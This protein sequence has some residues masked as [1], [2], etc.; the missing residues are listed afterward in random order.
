MDRH[1]RH[2]LE[3]TRGGRHEI[4][5]TEFWDRPVSYLYGLKVNG[6]NFMVL[7]VGDCAFMGSSGPVLGFHRDY[8]APLSFGK[9]ERLV[10]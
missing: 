6:R 8:G 5:W 1:N 3:M 7:V 2:L 9:K 10:V 4:D